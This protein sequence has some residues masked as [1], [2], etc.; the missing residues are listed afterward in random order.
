MDGHE[1]S[2]FSVVLG[3]RRA[4]RVVNG[5]EEGERD[6]EGERVQE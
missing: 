6:Q 2:F 5:L 3:P 4:L 1:P